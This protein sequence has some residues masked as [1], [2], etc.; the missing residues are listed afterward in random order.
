LRIFELE[1]EVLWEGGGL[2][3]VVNWAGISIVRGI[4][5]FEGEGSGVC[6]LIRDGEGDDIGV[7]VDA[8]LLIP[9]EDNTFIFRDGDDEGDED[10]PSSFLMGVIPSPSTTALSPPLP[11]VIVIRFITN[12][13][14][15]SILIP[16]S[17]SLLHV[18]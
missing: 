11:T 14:I 1:G 18:P 4:S 16:P 15:A 2:R 10:R 13:S 5:N 8:S 9:R 17:P 7:I 6:C 12:C 3:G